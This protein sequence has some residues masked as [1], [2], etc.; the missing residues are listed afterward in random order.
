[1]NLNISKFKPY[2]KWQK[3]SGWLYK[4]DK[5]KVIGY[6]TLGSDLLEWIRFHIVKQDSS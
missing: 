5:K 2:I 4:F 6:T 3:K 1:M